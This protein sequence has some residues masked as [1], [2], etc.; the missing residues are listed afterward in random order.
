M[1]GSWRRSKKLEGYEQK[2]RITRK[3][4]QR[5]SNKFEV[6]SFYGATKDCGI[7]S[8]MRCCR[9]EERCLRKKVTL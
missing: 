9:I 8:E 1:A 5:H 7:S 3:E 4:F 6:E 2:G